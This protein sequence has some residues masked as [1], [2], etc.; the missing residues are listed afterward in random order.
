[1]ETASH[2]DLIMTTLERV[3]VRVN[4]YCSLDT[5]SPSAVV[6]LSNLLENDGALSPGIENRVVI[7]LANIQHETSISTY[8]RTVPL[9]E[10]SFA[11]VAKPMYINLY[12]LFYA[13]FSGDHYAQGLAAI[14]RIISFFQ[15]TPSFNHDNTPELDTAIDKLTFE[16]TNLDLTEQNYLLG[17]FGVK[18]LPSAYYKIRML[19]FASGAIQAE[20]PAVRGVRTPSDAPEPVSLDPNQPLRTRR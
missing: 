13:N 12:V 15:Q 19:P 7:S 3:R 4:E 1:M 9:A 2:S 8:N 18:Y 5:A 20:V 6:V 10:D 11:A 17:Q 16:L 14:S